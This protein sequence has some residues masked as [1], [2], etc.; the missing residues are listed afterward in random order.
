MGQRLRGGIDAVGDFG[1]GLALEES[2]GQTGNEEL[3]RNP[4]SAI[5]R[6]MRFEFATAQRIIFGPE[7]VN[8]AGRLAKGLGR[9]ALV[10]I[11]RD[12]RRVQSVVAAFGGIRRRREHFFRLRRT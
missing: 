8:Q 4:Q 5:S 9:H 7:T 2:G 10:V 11:G 3:I 6:V 12:P 1:P